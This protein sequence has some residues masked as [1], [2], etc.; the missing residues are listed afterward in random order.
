MKRKFKLSTFNKVLT[1]VG[2]ILYLLITFPFTPELWGELSW[3]KGI[4][5]GLLAFLLIPLVFSWIAWFISGRKKFTANL[6]FTLFL[7][8]MV[9]LVAW[10]QFDTVSGKIQ[11]IVHPDLVVPTTAETQQPKNLRE[12]QHSFFTFKMTQEDRKRV[13]NWQKAWKAL[14]EPWVFDFSSLQSKK[15][16]ARQRKV[17][18]EY[19]KQSNELR[20]YLLNMEQNSENRV[21]KL[22]K[23]PLITMHIQYGN[24]M[25][26][27]LSLLEENQGKWTLYQDSVPI[28]R[29]N[30]LSDKYEELMTNMLANEN[31]MNTL[32]EK[33]NSQ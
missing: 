24:S 16:Y 20:N 8:L 28:F 26:A 13:E 31:E 19:V 12:V 18:T 25:L 17:I 5:G 14:Q 33:N 10:T 7:V 15:D 29:D 3:Y 6:T 23:L 30:K 22:N 4:L 2:C 11:R 32:I 9:V 27:V 21:E 1:A